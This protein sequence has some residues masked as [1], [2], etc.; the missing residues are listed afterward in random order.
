[1]KLSCAAERRCSGAF[2]YGKTV[3]TSGEREAAYDAIDEVV[4]VGR[5]QII[6][7][8]RCERRFLFALLVGLTIASHLAII[9]EDNS[10]LIINIQRMNCY[11]FTFHLFPLHVAASRLAQLR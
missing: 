6:A 9:W 5:Q 11:S 2:T 7:A 10:E 8:S 3:P 4:D 1:M